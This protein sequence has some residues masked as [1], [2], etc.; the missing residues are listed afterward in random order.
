[1]P[2]RISDPGAESQES[3]IVFKTV[4]WLWKVIGNHQSSGVLY[5][6]KMLSDMPNMDNSRISI[7]VKVDAFVGGVYLCVTLKQPNFSVGAR[8]LALFPVAL[9]GLRS[10]RRRCYPARRK[11]TAGPIAHRVV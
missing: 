4:R 3:E 2:S 5:R 7:G 10:F 11:M 8:K 6:P 9:Y 1:M